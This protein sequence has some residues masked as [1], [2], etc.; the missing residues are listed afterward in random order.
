M[1][2]AVFHKAGQSLTIDEVVS[3]E[4][5]PTDLLIQV[6]SCGICG[7]DLHF[8]DVH[9]TSGGMTPLPPGTVMGHEFCGEVVDVGSDVSG[10]LKVGRAVTA[11]PYR[12]CGA[13]QYCL[14]GRGHRCRS[15]TYTGLGQETG[16]YA[17]YM[18]VGARESLILPDGV[19]WETGALTEPLAVALHAVQLANLKA[20]ESVLIMGAGPIGLATALW[21]RFFGARHIVVSDR[22]DERLATATRMG[23]S[24]VVNETKESVV[25]SFKKQAKRRP[26]VIFECVGVPGTQQQAFDYAPTDGRIVVVGVCMSAD[27]IVPVKAITKELQ[28]NYAYMYRFQD[29][30][31]TIDALNRE[32]IDPTPMLTKTVGFE[33]FPTT[34]E[35]LKTDKSVCKVLLD[36]TKRE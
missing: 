1:R 16:G 35:S 18:R 34:F 26:E 24:C 3:P 31:V 10:E 21:C 36:P 28:V 33:E 5:G 9:D 27:H 2:A 4:P 22:I 23:A 12:G 20:G 15:V 30:E 25:G 19:D 13:C 29:F 8:S 7:S 17:E 6:R 32:L 11:L 14:S